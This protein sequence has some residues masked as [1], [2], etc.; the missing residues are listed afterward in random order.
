MAG[1]TRSTLGALGERHAESL[2]RA[3]GYRILERNFRTREGELDLVAAD[4]AALVF[5]EVK[6]RIA[7]SVQGPA[8]L[9]GIGPSKRRR[10][11][12]LARSWLSMRDE[13][14][15]RAPGIRF[16]AIGVLVTP[17]GGLV[18]IEHVED[19]FR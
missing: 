11:R 2:L 13:L 7:G 3:A 14:R 19:A 18:D 12:R 10:I 5:C 16:D 9:E 1:E 4:R 6:T 8:P 15:P 17:G